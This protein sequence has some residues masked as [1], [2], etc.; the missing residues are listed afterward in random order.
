MSL[1]WIAIIALVAWFFFSPT[2]EKPAPVLTLPVAVPPATAAQPS[3][4]SAHGASCL[5][6]LRK[7]L[8][9]DEKLTPELKAA[10][11]AI[12]AAVKD[13]GAA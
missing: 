5:V 7:Q 2:K 3:W 4:A 12:S 8:A 1:F 9:S 10:F 11:D 13:G 6:S